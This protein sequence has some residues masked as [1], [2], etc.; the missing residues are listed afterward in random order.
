MDYGFAGVINSSFNDVDVHRRRHGGGLLPR[1]RRDAG[2]RGRAAATGASQAITDPA[3]GAAA[4]I[5]PLAY[6][7]DTNATTLQS[8]TPNEI[9]LNASGISVTLAGKE[10][11]QH[12]QGGL[13]PGRRHVLHS[14]RWSRSRRSV[15]PR[16]LTTKSGAG[17]ITFTVPTTVTSVET[18][19]YVRVFNAGSVEQVVGK[20]SEAQPLRIGEAVLECDS[21]SSDGNFGTLKLPRTAPTPASWTPVNFARRPRGAADAR[22]S[23]RCR[24]HRPLRQRSERRDRVGQWGI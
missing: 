1:L 4:S 8:L 15:R 11:Q 9:A 3:S 7:G 21:A 18:A 20:R 6:D 14:Q 16:P 17:S 23:C 24:C 2:L 19:W 5:P 22:H 13:L 10:L 12:H